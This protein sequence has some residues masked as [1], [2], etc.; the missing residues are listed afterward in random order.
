MGTCS[1]AGPASLCLVCVAQYRDLLEG[2]RAHVASF[3]GDIFHNSSVS[4][5]D[6]SFESDFIQGGHH[7]EKRR[8]EKLAMTGVD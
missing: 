6:A 7:S 8:E 1:S 2:G 5:H 3:G 4:I